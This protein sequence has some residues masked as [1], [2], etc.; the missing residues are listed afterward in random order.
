M[1]LFIL[2]GFIFSIGAY[3]HEVADFK[4]VSHV[5]ERSIEQLAP[6]S[7]VSGPAKKT[8]F[9]TINYEGK[10]IL[11]DRSK[12]LLALDQLYNELGKDFGV[13]EKDALDKMKQSLFVLLS[14]KA[15]DLAKTPYLF[16]KNVLLNLPQES[17]HLSLELP[18][19]LH[20]RGAGSLVVIA[21]TQ[22]AWEVLESAVSWA[23]GAGGAHAYCVAFNI[24]LLRTVDSFRNLGQYLFFPG[25]NVP[26]KTRMKAFLVSLRRDWFS[27]K[28]SL[29]KLETKRKIQLDYVNQIFGQ[30]KLNRK[31]SNSTHET[32]LSSIEADF[33][34]ISNT[35]V[36]PSER[37]WMGYQ[38]TL[39]I[40]YL[41][42]VLNDLITSFMEKNYSGNNKELREKRDIY[43]FIWELRKYQGLIH[44][45][46]ERFRVA[47]MLH[48]TANALPSSVSSLVNMYGVYAKSIQS[49][50]QLILK[51][52][53]LLENGLVLSSQV[54]EELRRKV[55]SEL[56][57]NDK[58]QRKNIYLN[59]FS[60]CLKGIL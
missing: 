53:N 31:V 29:K 50:H 11:L 7:L 20:S 1:K 37:I 33:F 5:M 51:A 38:V 14:N 35:R 30:M 54:S 19:L 47:I 42:T 9:L 8:D 27:G 12:M 3:G 49:V 32:R 28:N 36:D 22:I 40:E 17:R 18:K 46:K 26:F 55:E 60:K 52:N 59:H 45:Q 4:A 21:T 10:V 23:I 13:E 15:I 39:G 25:M 24:A 44:K 2:L 58:A 16:F 57:R 34:R 41:D 6:E 56:I 48:S 43:D